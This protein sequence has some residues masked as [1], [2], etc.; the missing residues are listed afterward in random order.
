[1][2]FLKKIFSNPRQTA[3]PT[4][5]NLD[6]FKKRFAMVGTVGSG[7]STVAAGIIM[8]AQTLSADDPNFYGEVIE[9][10]SDIIADASKLKRGHFPRKTEAYQ[11]YP[12]ESGLV[13]TWTGSFGRER[14][15][16][17]PICD[18][19]GEDVQ[20]MIRQTRTELKPEDFYANQQ[21]LNYIRD[22]DGFLFCVPASRALIFD[23]DV[24]LEREPSSDEAV[25]DPDVPVTRIL[26]DIIN[27]KTRA[28]GKPIDAIGVIIT[29]SDLILPYL[30]QWGI[31]LYDPKGLRM[32]LN[33]Y[34]SATAMTLKRYVD[35]AN[36][37]FFPS[38]FQVLKNTDGSVKKWSDG[39]DRIEL[40]RDLR[41]PQRARKVPRYSEQ[42][43]VN[44][45]EWLRSFAT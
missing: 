15:L 2:S 30:A 3:M 42:S 5:T 1:M 41:N 35:K 7:K 40:F 44:L 38:H 14:K 27:Y 45:F 17:I 8:T 39:G 25:S 34:F 11:S 13:L 32:F 20:Q 22:A 28:R 43:Y 21:L 37:Q 18:I 29:K 16:Q 19:A 36:V 6:K 26:Q 31:D 23:D 12:V 9:S 24:Q 4:V 33:N 10:N